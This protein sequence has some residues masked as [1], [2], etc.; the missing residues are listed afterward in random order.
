MVLLCCPQCSTLPL[1]AKMVYCHVTGRDRC[2]SMLYQ[3]CLIQHE[4]KL[5]RCNISH[6]L[7]CVAG[8][9]LAWCV[10]LPSAAAAAPLPPPA[11]LPQHHSRSVFS[12]SF[13]P[14]HAAA[15]PTA[16]SGGALPTADAASGAGPLQA[17]PPAKSPPMGMLTSSMDR[18]AAVWR[19]Q[20]PS[21]QVDAWKAAKV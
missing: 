15:Q 8:S 14:L 4:G 18:S 2:H 1:V 19:L 7:A 13:G 10:P 11:R 17:L 3:H 16:P 12:I 21:P 5:P 6:C 9:M 20:R